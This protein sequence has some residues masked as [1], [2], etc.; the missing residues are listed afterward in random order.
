MKGVL[1][2]FCLK[3]LLFSIYV[4]NDFS[5]LRLR[6]ADAGQSLGTSGRLRQRFKQNLPKTLGN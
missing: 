2:D 1:S 5:K 4:D 6:P 3:R